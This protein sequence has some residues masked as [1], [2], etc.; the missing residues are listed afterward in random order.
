MNVDLTKVSMALFAGC[1]E[2]K[3]RKKVS[4]IQVAITLKISGLEKQLQHFMRAEM[5][6]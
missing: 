5:C 3:R 6:S 1:P 4:E 2:K